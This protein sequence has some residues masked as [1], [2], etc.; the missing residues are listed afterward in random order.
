MRSHGDQIYILNFDEL[1]NRIGNPASLQ[2]DF[3]LH[4]I[5]ILPRRQL[6]HSLFRIRN[7]LCIDL[8]DHGR[9]DGAGMN[10]HERLGY[11][12]NEQL[13]SEVTGERVCIVTRPIGKIRKIYGTEDPL[14]F[15]HCGS[16]ETSGGLWLAS[17]VTSMQSE[18]PFVDVAATRRLRR[19]AGWRV[20]RPAL[21]RSWI[22]LGTFM[23][24]VLAAEAALG[25]NLADAPATLMAHFYYEQ[26]IRGKEPMRAPHSL[27]SVA[28]CL[29]NVRRRKT[30][31]LIV[32]NPRPW[33]Y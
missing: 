29:S 22:V 26:E 1:E 32:P 11:M 6:A 10:W 9:R 25:S 21:I 12:Q 31:R 17:G 16:S 2:N 23:D 14:D 7:L 19:L 20:R 30:A 3:V 18:I 28:G 13:G 24:T 33:K 27:C 8:I 5:P 15:Q 4:V